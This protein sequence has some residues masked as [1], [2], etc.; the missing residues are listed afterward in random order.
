MFYSKHE[1]KK[2]IKR[3]MK[4]KNLLDLVQRAKNLKKVKLENYEHCEFRI[5]EYFETLDLQSART[6]FRRNSYMLKTIRS[7]YKSDRKYKAEGYLCPDCLV[8]DPPVSHVDTQKA[9]LT[10]KGNDDLRQGLDLGQLK[11]EATF[12][13]SVATRRIHKFGG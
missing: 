10:C 12:Y 8:L 1:Y 7:N 4:S 6:I 11:Q 5:Q 9:L 2:L 13:Q 3:K